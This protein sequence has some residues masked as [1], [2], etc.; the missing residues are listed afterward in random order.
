MSRLFPENSPLPRE[1]HDRIVEHLRNLTGADITLFVYDNRGELEVVL[2]DQT[3]RIG[4][5]RIIRRFP[6]EMVVR[7]YDPLPM[8]S[9]L[10]RDWE[11]G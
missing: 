6:V 9:D 2:T 7:S 8:F 5:R 1:L 4:T 11:A 3:P 10:V